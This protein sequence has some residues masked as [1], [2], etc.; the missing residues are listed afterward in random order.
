[1]PDLIVTPTVQSLT[2][3]RSVNG[4]A[5]AWPAGAGVRLWKPNVLG[6]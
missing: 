1:M 5:R 4:V 2:V 3:T 6:M